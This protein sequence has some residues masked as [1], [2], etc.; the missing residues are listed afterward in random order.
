MSLG[1]WRKQFAKWKHHHIWISKSTINWGKSPNHH[2]IPWLNMTKF[3]KSSL[4]LA[5]FNSYQLTSPE[6]LF[7]MRSPRGNDCEITI[8]S[9]FFCHSWALEPR[10]RRGLAPSKRAGSREVRCDE[11]CGFCR[12][13][14]AT[15]RYKKHQ[16]NI[17]KTIEFRPWKNLVFT[18]VFPIFH[19]YLHGFHGFPIRIGTLVFWAIFAGQELRD[20]RTWIGGIP[21]L[22]SM[23]FKV[24]P[25]DPGES[26]VNFGE[27]PSGNLAKIAMVMPWWFSQSWISG[28]T[29]LDS[30]VLISM[31]FWDCLP[32]RV[33]PT[34]I[35]WMVQKK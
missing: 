31:V 24:G 35:N 10:E 21:H 5:M 16:Q 23:A 11:N 14:K 27:R 7:S 29:Q 15:N 1:N 2:D 19:G 33:F 34:Y 13:P 6:G 17:K 30:M 25:W 22:W 8:R 9:C 18:W 3:G 4:F 20:L 32:G 12:H 28:F 26:T